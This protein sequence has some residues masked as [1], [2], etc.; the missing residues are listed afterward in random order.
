MW[1]QE[2]D[3][4]SNTSTVVCLLLLS[5]VRPEDAKPEKKAAS[6][7]AVFN[8]QMK[9]M[10]IAGKGSDSDVDEVAV[11]VW[12]VALSCVFIAMLLSMM[13]SCCCCA[14]SRDREARE[15]PTE[16]SFVVDET[17]VYAY[18]PLTTTEVPEEG[19]YK[20]PVMEPMEFENPIKKGS[21]VAQVEA[22]VE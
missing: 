3:L 18:T 19:D 17:E 11:P 21:F 12:P 10:Q 9:Q 16:V 14:N 6:W 22:Q 5:P 7:G 1:V 15:S 8:Q 20:P 2:S 4:V 13:V